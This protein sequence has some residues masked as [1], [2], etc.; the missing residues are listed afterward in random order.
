MKISV[1]DYFWNRRKLE[2]MDAP[3]DYYRVESVENGIIWVQWFMGGCLGDPQRAE[4]RKDG[5]LWL[6]DGGR[7]HR[8]I[9]DL[10]I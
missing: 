1:G 7:L 9:L 5:A 10:K 3:T 6:V 2:T 4:V 8:A